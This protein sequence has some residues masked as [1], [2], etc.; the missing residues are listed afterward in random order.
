VAA[1]ELDSL[2][3][4]FSDEHRHN[5]SVARRKRVVTQETR[6]K[7]SKTSTGKINIKKI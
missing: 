7:A 1:V 5:L 6:D 3:I 4:K 2:P